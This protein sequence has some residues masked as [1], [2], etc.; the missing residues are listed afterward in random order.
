MHAK[1]HCSKVGRAASVI[2]T[3]ICEVI[4]VNI[5]M[6]VPHLFFEEGGWREVMAVSSMC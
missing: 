3:S 2:F 5:F 6:P 1:Q 4:N